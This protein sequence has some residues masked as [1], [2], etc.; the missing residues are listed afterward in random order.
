[1]DQYTAVLFFWVKRLGMPL[2]GVYHM[3]CSSVF[4]NTEI[5]GDKGLEYWANQ[6]LAP[7]HYLLAGRKATYD[8]KTHQYKIE[9]RFDYK[10]HFGVKTLASLA[11]LPF[12]VTVGSGLKAIAYLDASVQKRHGAVVASIGRHPVQSNLAYY[13]ELGVQ[14]GNMHAPDKLRSPIYDRSDHATDHLNVYKTALKDI[15]A[16]LKKHDIPY[17]LDCGTL[18][19][20]YRYRG[21][22]PWDEDLDIAIL[23]PDFDNVKNALAE[24][25]PET[26]Q[27]LDWSSRDKA[28]TYLMVHIKST[29]YLIDIY[30][31]G[32]ETDKKALRGIVSNIDCMFLPNS[33]KVREGRFARS[34]PYAMVFPLKKTNFEGIEVYVPNDTPGYLKGVYGEDLRPAKIYNKETGHYEKDLTHPYWQLEYAH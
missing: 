3:L 22:I 21:F 17:W 18:L 30:H 4:F 1:M 10:E 28:K 26:Y 27:V 5:E 7:V 23:Q 24:L 32:I 29:G 9:Q 14:V 11:A 6:A 33:W 19:G 20:A 34:V 2:V 15:D 31:F 16:I 13:R 12:S 25:D 8:E